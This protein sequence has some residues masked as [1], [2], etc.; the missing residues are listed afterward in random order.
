MYFVDSKRK[1]QAILSLC[2]ERGIQVYQ[3]SGEACRLVGDGVDVTVHDLASLRVQDL[4]PH[5]APLFP[6]PRHQP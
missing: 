1:R 4:E 6:K 2:A 3:L 5:D